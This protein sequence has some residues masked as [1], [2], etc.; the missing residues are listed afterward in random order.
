MA[1][2]RILGQLLEAGEE[3]EAL[4]AAEMIVQILPAK[5]Q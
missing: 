3:V 2:F 1:V 4:D 5:P